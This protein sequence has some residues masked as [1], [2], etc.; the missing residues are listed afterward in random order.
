MGPDESSWCP[1]VVTGMGLAT[2]PGISIDQVWQ[3]WVG[4]D[5]AIARS[6]RL[7]RLGGDTILAAEVPPF[8]LGTDLRIPK[9]EKFMSAGVRFAVRAARE[10]LRAAHLDLKAVDPYRVGVYTGSG[11]TGMESADFFGTLEAAGGHDE[12]TDFANMGGRASRALDRYF[13]L[14]SLSNAGLGLLS[15]EMEAKG[16]SDNFVQDDAASA[17]A[18]VSG[19]RD[20]QDGRCDVAIAGGYDS[21]LTPSHYLSYK[22][23]G[24]LSALDVAR[25]YRPFDRERDGLVLGEGAGFLILEREEDARRRGV[26]PMG[27]LLG[28]GSA[29]E[30]EDSAHAKASDAAMRA[31]VERATRGG[32]V[33]AV[34]AHGIGTQDGDR[35]EASVLGNV[36][37]SEVPVTALKS[38]T[39]YI[40]AATAIVEFIIGMRAA[41]ERLLPP[42]ARLEY[43]DDDCGLNL[44]Q[45][46]PR[47]LAA[48]APTVVTVSWS[49]FGG[50]AAMAGRPC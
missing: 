43:R 27:H 42:I 45:G 13:S 44:V 6:N 32:A 33:D 40:G 3:K 2:P 46:E 8:D 4:S 17:M 26:A 18:V 47:G 28:V 10:A 9:N 35:R 12:A 37:G 39:G 36:F 7:D 20:L 5:S 49:W 1:V 41:R 29:M 22:A 19:L 34:V 14:R 30:I 48:T 23:T 38:L 50:C 21:L 25:A 24:L 11:Q 31:A 15:I 16:P